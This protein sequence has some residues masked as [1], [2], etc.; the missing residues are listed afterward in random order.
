M[1]ILAGAALGRCQP[2]GTD[3]YKKITAAGLALAALTFA[4]FAADAAKSG[5]L[6]RVE[7]RC[8]PASFNA[9]LGEGACVG[10][11]TTTFD[12]F[13]EDLNPVDFGDD[14]WRFQVSGSSIKRGESIKVVNSGG[15]FHTFTEVVAYGGGCVPDLNIPL[16][17]TPVPECEP[18]LPPPDPQTDPPTPPTPVAF[19]TTGLPPLGGTLKVTPTTRGTH[20]YLCLIH[21]WMRADVVVR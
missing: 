3:M 20:H 15:E 11:G 2:K 13:A 6:A 1:T 4:P 18:V 10:N 16:G 14:H 19:V 21:P 5:N 7:D 9:V 12:E 17:L 8:E